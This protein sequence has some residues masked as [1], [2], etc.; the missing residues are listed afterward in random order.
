MDYLIGS[1]VTTLLFIL[2]RRIFAN[3]DSRVQPLPVAYSQSYIYRIIGPMVRLIELTKRRETQVSKYE[4]SLNIK[5]VLSE[6]KAYWITN[7]TFYVANEE[8]GVIDKESTKP[9]DTISMDKVQLD[10][11]M[12]IVE[13][14][15]E[16]D[17]DEPRNSRK[18]GL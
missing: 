17:D 10:K 13:A 1:V 12:F 15:T 2:G 3:A 7:N 9:V 4:D 18:Q 11:M 6:N 16:G 14:L 8:D 5:V